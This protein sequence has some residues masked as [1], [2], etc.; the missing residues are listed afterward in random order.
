MRWWI[1]GLFATGCSHSR[2]APTRLP[3]SLPKPASSVAAPPPPVTPSVDERWRWMTAAGETPL[4]VSGTRLLAQKATSLV[5]LDAKPGK[6]VTSCNAEPGTTWKPPP[7]D[8]GLGSAASITATSGGTGKALLSWSVY[9][10]YAG[11]AQPTDEDLAAA[12]THMTGA[13]QV[14]LSVCTFA[15]RGVSKTSRP[16]AD[17]GVEIA[18]PDGSTTF[19]HVIASRMID[20]TRVDLVIEMTDK[21]SRSLLRR[22][23]GTARTREVELARG[24]RGE[25]DA[26]LSADGRHAISWTED[27]ASPSSSGERYVHW[28]HDAATATQRWKFSVPWLATDVLVVGKALISASPFGV[29]YYVP[30]A[31]K[32]RWKR[33]VRQTDY[34]GPMP[35]S[36]AR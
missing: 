30:G 26:A 13:V 23:T 15:E 17:G 12:T 8:A 5:V 16:A 32:E 6:L 3:T 29:H 21:H 2:P 19:T 20:G 34:R 36:A 22:T 18:N 28:V 14:D 35:P 31:R 33:S 9:T 4:W 24:P 1:V 10:R 27:V 25:L 7:I 11:G